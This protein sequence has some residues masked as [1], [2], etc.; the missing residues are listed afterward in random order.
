MPEIL[1]V[2]AARRLLDERALRRPIAHVYAPDAW[3]LKRGLTPHAAGVALRGTEMTAAEAALQ[4]WKE[5]HGR[6]D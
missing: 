2:E 1:E 6:V 4:S 3:F 5:Y